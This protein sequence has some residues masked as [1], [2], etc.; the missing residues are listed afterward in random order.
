MARARFEMPTTPVNNRAYGEGYYG[1]YDADTTTTYDNAGNPTTSITG[2][3]QQNEVNRYRGMADAAANRGAYQVNFDRANG[4]A[5]NAIRSR[6]AQMDAAGMLSNAAHGNA[7]SAAAIMGNQVGNQSLA[8]AL[9]MQAA[10][11]GPGQQAFAARQAMMQQQGAQLGGL[12]QFAGMRA[13]EMDAARGAYMGGVTGMRGQDYQGQALLQ[14]Q[15]EAQAQAEN[16]QRD[17]NQQGQMGYEGMGFD[18]N[19]AVMNA[20]LQQRSI[21]EQKNEADRRASEA[22][23][24]RAQKFGSAVV[25]SVGSLASYASQATKAGDKSN[26]SGANNG[27]DDG[28]TS[29]A[30]AKTNSRLIYSDNRT[31]LA[32]AGRQAYLL[33]RAH[34]QEQVSTGKPVEFAYGGPP[35]PSEDIVD[36]DPTH[37]APPPPEPSVLERAGKQVR[38]AVEKARKATEGVIDRAIPGKSQPQASNDPMGNALMRMQPYSYQYKPEFAGAEGQAQGET[39]IGP[40]AQDM[41]SHPI[42]ATAIKEDQ[43]GLLNI[44]MPKATKLNLAAVGYL[45]KKQAEQDARLRAMEDRNGTG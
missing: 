3:S 32:A 42:T 19:A 6:N 27:G 36:A 14:R 18:V 26:S 35:K 40:M 9:R 25:G 22:Q 10:G 11:R 41:A 21:Q 44:D 20:G 7:P 34:Q 37:A 1:G 29:D 12:S 4:D 28:T 2:T 5:L 43:D 45:A 39:N 30:R 17:L 8:G 24:A 15:A 23:T 13:G 16:F 33:G 31:K 38:G